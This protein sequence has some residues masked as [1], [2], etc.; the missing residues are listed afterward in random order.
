MTSEPEGILFLFFNFNKYHYV[1]SF[2]HYIF[3]YSDF[4][5]MCYA[6][7]IDLVL[8]IETRYKKYDYITFSLIN[9]EVL[10]FFI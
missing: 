3:V 5:S 4:R 8:T 1:L 9:F 6:C 2:M 10:K 7:C